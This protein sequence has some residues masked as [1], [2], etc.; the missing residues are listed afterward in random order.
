M[1]YENGFG[2]KIIAS[3]RK[4][5]TKAVRNG[6]NYVALK[7]GSEYK[8][9]LTNNKKV[10]AMAT[11]QI[12]GVDVGTWLLPKEDSITIDRPAH[13][14]RKFT[15]FEE[16]DRRAVSA[17]VVA[18]DDMN[19]VVR[20]T[21]LPKKEEKYVSL[22]ELDDDMM[23]PTRLPVRSVRSASPSFSMKSESLRSAP[24]RAQSLMRPSFSEGRSGATV[25]GS[26][27][28]QSFKKMKK[29]SDDEVDWDNQTEIIIR[30]IV[31]KGD[32]ISIKRS[33][34]PPRIDNISPISIPYFY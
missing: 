31:E 29:F 28:T 8:I 5:E 9:L 4:D 3:E 20:V 27:S 2:V 32:F 11:I 23:V 6:F 24:L 34:I 30:I 10:P 17:G 15:F 14:S 22:D 25:L 21:F 19:G 18:G 13:I 16:N 7:N 1:V 12:D 26:E 33:K